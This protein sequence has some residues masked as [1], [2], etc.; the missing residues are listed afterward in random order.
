MNRLVFLLSLSLFFHSQVVFSEDPQMEETIVTAASS[1]QKKMGG[2]GSGTLLQTKEIEDTSPTHVSE[3][4]NRVPGVW[5]NRGS[6]QEHLTAIRS[7]VLTGSGACGE[8]SFMQDGIPLRPQGFC[9]I[10]NLFELNFEQASA[11]EV[12][13]GPASAVIGGNAMRG[14]INA[15]TKIPNSNSVSLEVGPYD[16]GRLFVE[17]ASITDDY[18]LGVSFV[19]ADSGGYRDETGY[20]QQKL[21]ANYLTDMNGWRV[22][23]RFSATNLNQE[24]G[25]YVRGEDAY[26]DS[27]LRKSNPNPEAYRDAWSARIDSEISKDA[28]VF[29]PYL[30][31]SNMSFLQHFLPGQPLEENEQV[32]GGILAIFD[33]KR[34]NIDLSYG[35]QVE[36]MS[37]SLRE[38]QEG[39]TTGSNFLV[40]T[41]PSGLHYDYDVTSLMF[42]GFFNAEYDV[43]ARMRFVNSARVEQLSY[44][45]ENNHIVGNTKDDGTP[46]G[47]GG[48][49]YTRPASRSDDFNN[50]GLRIGAEYD[51]PSASVY[52]SVSNGFRP[53]QITELYRLRGGQTIADLKS[54]QLMAGEIGVTNRFL[55]LAYFSDYTKNYLFRDSEAYNVSD[56]RVRARGIELAANWSIGE[57][58]LALSVTNALHR[59]AFTRDADGR[60][61]IATGNTLD[62]AP[63]YFGHVS[64]SSTVFGIIEHE[65][66]A[67]FVGSYYL[68]AANTARYD[69]HQVLNWRFHWDVNQRTKMS[70]RLMNL[71]DQEYA[72]RADFAFGSYRYFPGMPFQIYLGVSHKF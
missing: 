8:F 44:D 28:V 23:N 13:R 60:E 24:T 36:Y 57:N 18:N 69:G 10:N 37:G 21:T 32:S 52:A 68:N 71:L 3:I 11:L 72:D 46:C 58:D 7:A 25:G 19:G 31:G 54:E 6:G 66:E 43:G 67:I 33:L 14:A 16:F 34:E 20:G 5:V 53:P 49:L 45:Y 9:N 51:F 62:S 29:K 30:R 22:H 41:R 48:C 35:A 39:P 38:F 64:W 12:W 70:L 26:S 63:R 27:V 40:A 65:L 42:A 17:G 50:V 55:T 15:V 61:K 47:F 56:G 4:V 2:I 59:Y 1:L